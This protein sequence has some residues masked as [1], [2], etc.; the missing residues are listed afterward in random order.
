MAFYTQE[1]ADHLGVH[2]E[3][4]SF[5]FSS[6]IGTNGE[7]R[8]IT[9]NYK[10]FGSPDPSSSFYYETDE[11]ARQAFRAYFHNTFGTPPYF[12]GIPLKSWE[13]SATENSFEWRG[14]LTFGY[15]DDDNDDGQQKG[16]TV[17]SSLS[18]VQFGLSDISWSFTTTTEN[19]KNTLETVG[20]WSKWTQYK[21]DEN[22]EYIKDGD[23]QPILEYYMKDYGGRIGVTPD[24]ETLGVDVVKPACS[25]SV[26]C[27]VNA[28]TPFNP[29]S[30][31]SCVG[32][33]NSLTWGIFG[34]REVL[35]TGA[36]I[37]RVPE[38]VTV[39]PP[40]GEPYDVKVWVNEITF[41]FQFSPSVYIP[42]PDGGQILKKGFDAVWLSKVPALQDDRLEVETMQI[43]LERI[44]PVVDFNSVFAFTWSLT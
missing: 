41:N 40:V 13:F 15:N 43:N 3:K 4:Q 1:L 5:N 22:G 30:I 17:Q 16:K 7:Q 38:S 14:A 8:D 44:Y 10:I 18:G 27:K 23:G 28:A 19:I 2:E 21:K 11:K 12:Q 35:F 26:T 29:Y 9:L 34:P 32:S 25:F 24:G 33:V 20:G 37:K 6:S 39:T 31:L 42:T 36:D